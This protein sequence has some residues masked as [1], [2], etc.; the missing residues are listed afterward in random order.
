ML[1]TSTN[2][3]D[4]KRLHFVLSDQAGVPNVVVDHQ[5]RARVYYVDFG[6][7][8]ILATARQETAGSLTNWT[9]HR[10]HIR[11]RKNQQA[12]GPVDP[13]VVTRPNGRYRLYYMQAAPTPAVYSAI[14]TNGFDFTEEPEVR[15]HGPSGDRAPDDAQ[16]WE[17]VFDPTVLPT[18]DGWL[19]WCGPDGR[20]TA[21]AADGLRFSP[22]GEFRVEGVRFMT[23][24][25]V[26]LPDKGGYRLFGNYLGP[27]EWSGGI[28]SVFSP[29]GITW[30]REPG[31]RLSLDGSRYPLEA[32][33]LPDNG[34]AVLPDGRWLMAYL[35]EIPRPR[36]R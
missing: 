31:N 7:G 17:P 10:V 9:Y 28:S 13:A 32:R 1:A 35:A 25:A 14:S 21:R 15:F 18:A 24:S 33:F 8:N 11:S 16:R 20:F 4:F 30:R 12:R 27:G 6:N 26:A 2:G 3:L 5:G 23:W 36:Q 29:E 34:C 22:R 19:M